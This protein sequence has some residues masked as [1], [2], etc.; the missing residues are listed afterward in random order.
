[1]CLNLLLKNINNLFYIRFDADCLLFDFRGTNRIAVV[2]ARICCLRI[3]C[4]HLPKRVFD[5][6]GCVVADAE[7]EE[8]Y[9][10]IT[11]CPNEVGVPFGGSVPA[12]VLDEFIVRTQIHCHRCAAMPPCHT[13]RAKSSNAM[14]TPG[15]LISTSSK[16]PAAVSRRW[17]S[18]SLTVFGAAQSVFMKRYLHRRDIFRRSSTIRNLLSSLPTI[19]M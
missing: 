10:L 6:D 8:K 5:N 17:N 3:F 14:E 19:Q 9:F 4:R 16:Q 11:S 1:M 2:Y 13:T 15:R 7:L 12:F 18:Q